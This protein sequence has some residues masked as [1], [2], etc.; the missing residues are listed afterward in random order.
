M[1]DFSGDGKFGA[2]DAAMLG[3]IMGFAEESMRE[4][5]FSDNNIGD[6]SVENFVDQQLE[7]PNLRLI[8][9]MN[10]QMFM[11]IANTVIKQQKKWRRQRLLRESEAID[12]EFAHELRAL[13]ETEA[14]LE[15][16]D[17]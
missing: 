8:Y 15:N 6:G 14:L 16:T 9:N 11:F 12:N 2:E 13:E 5:E 10:P 7:E 4:E 3:G 1:F 17:E